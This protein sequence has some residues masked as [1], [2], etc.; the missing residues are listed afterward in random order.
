MLL[1]LYVLFYLKKP[2]M[3]SILIMVE[4]I[5]HLLQMIKKFMKN[6]M[7]NMECN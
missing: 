4:K 2:D 3:L 1:S 7:K 5:C 6:M